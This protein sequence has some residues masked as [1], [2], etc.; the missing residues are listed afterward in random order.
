M[1]NE[2]WRDWI[3]I[4]KSPDGATWTPNVSSRRDS[5][6]VLINAPVNLK[7]I[8]RPS[9]LFDG[10]E[11]KLYFDDGGPGYKCG[12]GVDGTG[13]AKTLVATSTD[14]KNFYYQGIALQRFSI[15]PDV[16][17]FGNTYIMANGWFSNGIF[18]AVSNDGINFT[19]LGNLFARSGYAY[20]Q[21]ATS[22]PG[23][24]RDGNRLLGIWYGSHS[25]D[26]M[27]TSISAAYLQKKAVI[28]NNVN[29]FQYAEAQGPD[30]LVLFFS[31]GI[32]QITASLSV[33]DS[34]G[35]TLLYQSSPMQFNRGDV[36]NL[37]PT[38]SPT[39]SSS[40]SPSPSFTVAQLKTA[41]SNYL[42]AADSSYKPVDG[43]I[44]MLDAGYVIDWLH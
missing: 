2:S 27:H 6:V 18:G 34:G 32:N 44:N 28:S 21:W 17:K 10:L 15:E 23:I 33:Y 7:S 31:T 25:T 41:L 29:Y 8:A 5:E 9:L 35:Q 24:V 11:W 14:L 4:A 36:F 42:G 1:T 26:L 13:V 37:I 12:G 3:S 22:N 16:Q 20:D 38:P 40:P 19:D 30:E 43:K 39:P